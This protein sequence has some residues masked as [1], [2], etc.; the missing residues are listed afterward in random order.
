MIKEIYESKREVFDEGITLPYRFRLDS[1]KRLKSSIK[2]REEEIIQALKLDLNKQEFEAYTNEIGIVYEEIDLAIKNLKPWMSEIDVPTP[3][4]LQPAKSFIKREPKGVVL[5]ISPWNYPFQL[6]FSPL[7]GAIAAGNC[8]IIKT[9]SKSKHTKTL[10][11]SI[12]DDCFPKNY[13]EFVDIENEEIN[14]L[15]EEYPLDHIFFTGS[16]KVGTS[17]YKRAATNLTPVTLELGGKS[18]VIVHEDANINDAAKSITWA[19]FLN[20]G[21]TCIAPDYLLI[22][23]TIAEKFILRM[24]HH[25]KKFYGND[26]ARFENLGKIIDE[27]SFDRVVELLNYGNIVE[28]GNYNREK[29]FIEPTIIRDVNMED[30]I[31]KEEIFGPLLPVIVYRDIEEC[32]AIIRRNRY[33][34]ALYMFTKDKAI[35]EFLLDR[36][37]FGGGCINSTISHVANSNLPFGG[38]GTSGIG[39]YH[40]K[41]TFFEFTNEKSI[42]KS[43]ISLGEGIKYPPYSSKKLELV[44]KVMK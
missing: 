12:I 34:L 18:P 19:K 40:S 13:I 42:Y 25:I 35:E 38:V 21:Q 37:E 10:M 44:R 22:H 27:G 1:L 6:T 23:E 43:T 11:Q 16:V 39:K 24:V 30:K 14:N 9:S 17:I 8:I 4:Y 32:L 41:Y 33:P 20:L 2:N 7:I 28:G 29:L 31:M 26:E 15:I 5:I 3:I 36:I